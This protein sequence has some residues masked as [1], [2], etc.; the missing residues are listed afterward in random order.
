M[1]SDMAEE[2]TEIAKEA[3]AIV[4]CPKCYGHDISVDDDDARVRAYKLAQKARRADSRGFRGMTA[5]DVREA[6]DAAIQDADIEC[7]RFP[8]R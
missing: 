3:G 5:Q 7:P 8:R 6:I 1:N 2:A 4:K